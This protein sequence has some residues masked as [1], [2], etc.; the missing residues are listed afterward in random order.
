[1]NRESGIEPGNAAY[2][3]EPAIG[4]MHDR[5]TGRDPLAVADI[6]FVLSQLAGIKPGWI[7]DF[8]CG[9]GRT[10]PDLSR[11]GWK[12]IGV[13]MS[14]PMLVA[15]GNPLA[16]GEIPIRIQSS[17]TDMSAFPPGSLDAAICLYST[18]GMIRGRHHRAKF[19]TRAREAVRD[20][21]VFVVHAHNVWS[22]RRFPGG[23][24]WLASS[25]IRSVFSKREFGDRWANAYGV[26]GLFIHSFRFGE[27][28]RDLYR[29]GWK[30]EVCWVHRAGN[31]SDGN[32]G[33]KPV[34][35]IARTDRINALGWIISCSKNRSP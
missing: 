20:G 18:L 13:D 14:W 31:P 26:Q 23:K 10:F 22:Q 32:S 15:A 30:P 3:R 9:T 34:A 16:N 7:A 33:E 21:G 1:M 29:A 19:L 17:L 12:V 6:Q 8:G 35:A 27:L 4:R 2:M 28:V 5:H 24:R 11:S 25:L